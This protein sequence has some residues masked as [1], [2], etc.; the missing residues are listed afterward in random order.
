MGN[1]KY[2]LKIK[3]CFFSRF[4]YIVMIKNIKICKQNELFENFLEKF[5][6][7]AKSKSIDTS[8]DI[9][10]KVDTGEKIYFFDIFF[11]NQIKYNKT[12]P[13]VTESRYFCGI[14]TGAN[15]P[16]FSGPA[17]PP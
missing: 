11:W 8:I 15:T 6:V 17:P 1:S 4:F 9:H 14:D 5:C 3:Y 16:T 12:H 7:K 10:K 2:L 13:T